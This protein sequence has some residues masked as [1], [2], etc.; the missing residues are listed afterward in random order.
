M[1]YLKVLREN[2]EKR[3]RELIE[4]NLLSKEYKVI[5]KG[6]YVFFPINKKINGAVELRGKKLDKK[7]TIRDIVGK[8]KFSS[9]DIIGEIAV[10]EIPDELKSKEKEIAKTILKN[11]P[12]IKTILRKGS[13]IKGEYRTREMKYLIGKRTKETVHKENGC[14]F[15][16]NVEDVYYSVRLSGERKR[17]ASLVKPKEKILALFAGVGPFPIVISKE[18]PSVEIIAI[19]LNPEGVKYMK[20]NIILNKMNNIKAVQGD[21]NKVIGKYRGWA[22][23]VLMP[24]P[25]SS[26][27]FLESAFIGAK[28]NGIIHFYSFVS[29]KGAF[30]TGKN[31]VK[32]EAKR[33]GY[34]VKI[35]N[36]KKV[37]D[38]APDIVQVVVD[39]KTVSQ[40][41][42]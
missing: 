16:L 25:K 8:G 10:V 7:K 18:N 31:I 36:V 32:K 3:R 13:R 24:L 4:K 14:R 9:F 2:A 23:R 29:S 35:L 1:L 33:L 30:E 40:K 34:K 41:K 28:N 20:E 12:H 17:I 26:K 5:R 22:N 15:K 27:E 39:F 42:V 6:E 11:H 37:R 21:V 38:F 19:E